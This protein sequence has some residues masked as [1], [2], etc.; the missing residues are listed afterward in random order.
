MDIFLMNSEYPTPPPPIKTLIAVGNHTHNENIS[1]N[2]GD[3]IAKYED[4]VKLLGVTIDF[5]LDCDE[6]ILKE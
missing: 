3:N 6:N 2:F 4:S 1:L 5:K